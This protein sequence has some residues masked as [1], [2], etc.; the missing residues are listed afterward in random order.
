M[1]LQNEKINLYHSSPEKIQVK[2]DSICTTMQKT[3]QVGKTF[4][5]KVQ[6]KH[7][8]TVTTSCWKCEI[9]EKKYG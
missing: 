5:S 8:W 4:N 3:K 9:C 6:H 2:L 1:W 7:R